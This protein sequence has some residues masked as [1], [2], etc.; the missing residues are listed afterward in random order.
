MDRHIPFSAFVARHRQRPLDLIR[1]LVI[2]LAV[3]ALPALAIHRM[4]REVAIVHLLSGPA[5]TISGRTPAGNRISLTSYAA[6]PAAPGSRMQ[7]TEE[8]LSL[9][10]RCRPAW[11]SNRPGSGA[12]GRPARPRW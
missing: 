6:S 9:V 11:P 7:G 1:G 5:V 4:A 10:A 3:V 2:A 12:P 8:S